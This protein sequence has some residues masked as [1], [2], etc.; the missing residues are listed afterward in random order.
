MPKAKDSRNYVDKYGF[1]FQTAYITYIT[2]LGGK[3]E[4]IGAVGGKKEDIGAAFSAKSREN[5]QN[6][7]GYS[8]FK[9]STMLLSSLTSTANQLGRGFEKLLQLA[10]RWKEV[11]GAAEP[12]PV[13][14][15]GSMPRSK[16]WHRS[17]T[18]RRSMLAWYN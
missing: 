6:D 9:F 2:L 10:R 15:F 14:R 7:L 16:S 5:S 11:A 3:K 1:F 18:M 12:R 4:D 17:C 13:R 8:T